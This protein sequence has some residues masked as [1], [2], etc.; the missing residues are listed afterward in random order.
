MLGH[1]TKRIGL[2][3]FYVTLKCY[4]TGSDLI[5]YHTLTLPGER[6]KISLVTLQLFN[7]N[8]STTGITL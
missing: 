2:R 6:K 7:G 5:Y 3:R 4:S 8:V 1:L